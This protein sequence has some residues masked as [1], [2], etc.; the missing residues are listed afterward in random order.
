M[1]AGAANPSHVPSV[2]ARVASYAAVAKTAARQGLQAPVDLLG[3]GAFFGV[4]LLIF[5]RLW[6]VVAAR[7]AVAGVGP[8]ELIWYLALTEW[9]ILSLPLTHLEIEQDVRSGDIAYRLTRPISYLGTRLAEAAGLF[10][11]RA[12]VLA[13]VGGGFAWSLAGGLPADPRGLALAPFLGLLA[14]ALGIVFMAWIGLSALWL[15]D[16]S[17]LYWVWQKLA[18]VLG[19]LMLPLE[20]YPAWLRALAEFTPFP[21]MMYSVGRTALA[22]DPAAAAGIWAQQLCWTLL[23]SVLCVWTYRRGLRALAVN[24]G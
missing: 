12:G 10:A 23:V 7:G 3:R 15:Q 4:I 13:L 22:F 1:S 19:G 11:I 2:R 18:F 20:I 17:P 6:E 9:V 16:S 21:S 5:S 14:G 24:G 8:G